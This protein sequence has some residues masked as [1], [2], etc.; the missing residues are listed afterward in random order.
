MDIKFRTKECV[1]KGK[2]GNNKYV[3][4]LTPCPHGNKTFFGDRPVMVGD[5][6]CMRCK[7]LESMDWDNNICHCKK[8][9]GKKKQKK[10][11]NKK[12]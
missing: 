6:S 4:N 10:Y 2:Y 12:N 11:G 1:I 7:N 5:M 3:K 9:K 8:E